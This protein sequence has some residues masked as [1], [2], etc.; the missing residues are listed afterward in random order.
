VRGCKGCRGLGVCLRGVVVDGAMSPRSHA[1]LRRFQVDPQRHAK[2]RNGAIDR[3]V[4]RNTT[5]VHSVQRSGAARSEALRSES[6]A[7]RRRDRVRVSAA[8]KLI[9]SRARQRA[10]LRNGVI[11]R[12][13][14]GN[15]TSVRAIQG[16]GAARSGALRSESAVRRRR[17]RTRVSAGF[18]WIQPGPGTPPIGESRKSPVFVANPPPRRQ[19]S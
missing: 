18:K 5:G 7:R 4:A 19:S 6:A 12:R 17:D 16:S 14:A 11:D 10:K 2:L 13:V 9:R 1:G 3:R 15:T 8:F